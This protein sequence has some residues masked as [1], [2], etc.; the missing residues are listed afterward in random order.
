MRARVHG[1]ISLSANKT[2]KT[3]GTFDA[4]IRPTPTVGYMFESLVGDPLNRLPE[5]QPTVDALTA[6]G[7]AMAVDP[8]PAES[9]IPAAY[10][11]FGQFIDHDITKTLFDPT[12]VGPSGRDPLA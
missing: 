12:L 6:L 4:A 1:E 11:Y 3:L 5:G 7:N 9:N 10:T 2:L 8:S